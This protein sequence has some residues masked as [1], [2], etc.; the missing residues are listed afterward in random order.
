MSDLLIQHGRVIDPVSGTDLHQSML[1]RDG[2]IAALG[3]SAEAGA[4][5]ETTVLDASH[6]VI[7]PGLIDIHV[8]FR[9]PGQS[10]KETIGTG[11][12]AAAL[13]GFTTVVCMPNTTPAVDNPGTV[14]LIQDKVEK[15]ALIRVHTTGAITRDIAGQ[16]LAPVG[17][18]H[19]AGVVAITDDGRCVQNHDL[20]RRACEYAKMF[21]LPLMDHCQDESVVGKG[22]MHEG[23]WSNV[24]GL[25]AWPA[26][27]EEIIV[28]RNIQLA[29][30]TGS[31]IHCQ[32]MSS[33]GA[34][35][36]IREAKS[37]GIPISGEACPHHFTLTD[38]AIA[39]SEAFWEEADPDWLSMIK[40]DYERPQW[41]AYDTLFKMNPPLR[42]KADREAVLQGVA[43][44][45]LEVIASD[46]APHCAYEKEREFDMAPF[47][48]T[49]LET[50]L[51]LGL[52]R[53]YHTGQLTLLELI[54]RWTSNPAR[55]MR[56]EGG[57]LAVGSRADLCLFDPDEEWIYDRHQTPS[58]ASNNPFHGWP[59]K[60]RNR[61][62][63]LEG[64]IV[65]QPS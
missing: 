53:L 15:D 28:S 4:G 38:A 24:L 22:V 61:Y 65:Y 9:E 17:S 46:H 23:H 14:A 51:A 43:D 7:C 54:R 44:G 50:Q 63:I 26:L 60:G 59:M 27:G 42:S 62:T 16:A 32:H 20:M 39:G 45:T 57:S 25:P 19:E 52:T 41:P 10:A 56:L 58:K 3:A 6:L 8:H 2:R 5:P 31:H 64:K 11:T 29:E 48:I 55:L 18:L 36:L 35:K 1:I 12:R 30:L 13:G 34:V 49:G 37:K 40:M 21:E 47:G 33:A